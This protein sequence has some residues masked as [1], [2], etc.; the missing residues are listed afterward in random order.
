MDKGCYNALFPEGRNESVH[1]EEKRMEDK[2]IDLA[3]LS[4][5]LIT[6]RYLFNKNEIHKGISRQ[7]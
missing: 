2:K 7:D 1:G 5:E 6:R 3:V 4:N